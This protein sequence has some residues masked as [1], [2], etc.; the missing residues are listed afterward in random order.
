MDVTCPQDSHRCLQVEETTELIAVQLAGLAAASALVSAPEVFGAFQASGCSRSRGFPAAAS[1]SSTTKRCLTP[2][3]DYWLRLAAKVAG[4][5]CKPGMDT[6]SEQLQLVLR[7]P[8]PQEHGFAGTFGSLLGLPWPA[9]LFMGLGTTALTL[10]AFSALPV[11]MHKPSLLHAR[12]RSP[13]S[14]PG[15]A[16]LAARTSPLRRWLHY[17]ACR[18]A[19]CTFWCPGRACHMPL[20][21]CCNLQT[22]LR[23]CANTAAAV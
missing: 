6:V 4:V 15:D 17:A 9:L 16:A 1:S 8:Q 2:A 21:Q 23:H 14:A 20:L 3:S 22:M 7:Y 11:L 10:C 12:Q 18:A 13:A 19:A 5:K